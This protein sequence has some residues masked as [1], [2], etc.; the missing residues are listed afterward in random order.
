M[1]KERKYIKIGITYDKRLKVGNHY[2]DLVYDNPK[3][4]RSAR[5][6]VEMKKN[7]GYNA[8]VVECEIEEVPKFLVYA[9]KK[10]ITRKKGDKK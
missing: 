7:D 3:T 6:I 2:W 9:R 10:P 8:R 5:N 4:I 1:T